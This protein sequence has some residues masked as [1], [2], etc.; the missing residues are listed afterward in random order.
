[1][2]EPVVC[3]LHGGEL[4]GKQMI[5][6]TGRVAGYP[7]MIQACSEKDYRLGVITYRRAGPDTSHY[8]FVESEKA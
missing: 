1:M 6:S 3:Y 4:D 8:D 5:L 7:A 2:S